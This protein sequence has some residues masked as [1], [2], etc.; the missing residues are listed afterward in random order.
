MVALIDNFYDLNKTKDQLLASKISLKHE[1]INHE[2]LKLDQKNKNNPSINRPNNL[3]YP[4]CLQN[5]NFKIEYY[6]K[7]KVKISDDQIRC[8]QDLK[9]SKNNVSSKKKKFKIL[10][11]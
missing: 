7:K 1:Y 4:A 2:K 11:F 8:E 10:N 6:W 3:I 9:G 5:L